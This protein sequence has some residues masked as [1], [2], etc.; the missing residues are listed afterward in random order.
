MAFFQSIGIVPLL[1]FVP[2]NRARYG[3]MVS[4]PIFSILLGMQPGPT[5]FLLPI[6][7]NLFLIMLVLMVKGYE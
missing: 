5:D 1:I 2:S 4:P 6:I 7:A 3:I